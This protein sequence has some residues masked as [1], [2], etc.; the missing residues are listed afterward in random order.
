MQLAV[1]DSRY[2][3]DTTCKVCHV[4]SMCGKSN[5]REGAWPAQAAAMGANAD[6]P[7]GFL[8]SLRFGGQGPPEQLEKLQLFGV[9]AGFVETKAWRFGLE[10]STSRG[11]EVSAFVFSFGR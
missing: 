5:F 7:Q 2:H 10:V 11:S 9:C 8:S 6:G 4:S 3:M 1:L